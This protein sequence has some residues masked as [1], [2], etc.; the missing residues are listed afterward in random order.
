MQ[1][2]YIN[3][4]HYDNLKDYNSSFKRGQVAHNTLLSS[5]SLSCFPERKIPLEL[6]DSNVL[7]QLYEETPV[8]KKSMRLINYLNNA[9]NLDELCQDKKFISANNKALLEIATANFNNSNNSEAKKEKLAVIIGALS[10]T[11][12]LLKANNTLWF[13]PSFNGLFSYSTISSDH[14]KKAEVT[15]NRYATS[16]AATAGALANTGV[17]DAIALTVITKNMC[18]SIFRTYNLKG[19]YTAALM[20]IAVG[21]VIGAN[22]AT[23]ILTI[24]PGLGN[25]ANGGITYGLHQLTGHALV[26]FCE[27]V[28]D[29][30]LLSSTD[31]VARYGIRLKHGLDFIKNDTVREYARKAIDKTLDIAF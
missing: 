21:S 6:Y 2:N 30:E 29:D 26:A 5:D 22:L 17:G 8:T 3:P 27:S 11:D 25:I 20:P 23:T 7:R 24:Q 19:G 9:E 14:K 13:K 16:A 15:I 28:K 10:L 18:K 31:A 12:A 4:V 1:I